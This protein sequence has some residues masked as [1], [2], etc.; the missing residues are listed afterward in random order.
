MLLKL[1]I[2]YEKTKFL[3]FAC[4]KNNLPKYD[5]LTLVSQNTI[6]RS[7]S[8]IKY[9]GV[10]IDSHLRWDIHSNN[11]AGTLR[12]L[13]YKFKYLR[14]FLLINQLKTIYYA[15][16]ESRLQY[17]IL[18]WGGIANTHLKKLEILQKRIKNNI[19]QSKYLP[20]R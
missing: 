2:N 9:L 18:S 17:A 12:C 19:Q 1:T 10:T 15:L 7:V 14:N 3:P 13:V 4:Y 8:N 5:T 11:I 16:V 20:V 6:L